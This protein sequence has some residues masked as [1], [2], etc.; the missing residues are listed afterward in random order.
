MACH[1]YPIVTD[2]A[3]NQS[4]IKHRENGQ[5]VTIND[6]KM[7]AEEIIWANDNN[8]YREK[9]LLLIDYLLKTMPKQT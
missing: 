1:T 5:L 3:G 2:I 8:I 7:L 6:Y 4:W 9:Q